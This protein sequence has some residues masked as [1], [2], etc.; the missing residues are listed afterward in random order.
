MCV[1]AG[2]W[3]EPVGPSVRMVVW[4]LSVVAVLD[5]VPGLVG[6]VVGPSVRAVFWE[7][8]D[9]GVETGTVKLLRKIVGSPVN[10][11]DWEL[12]LGSVVGDPE[13]SGLIVGVGDSPGTMVWEVSG[14]P[15]VCA[16]AELLWKGEEASVRAVLG[17]LSEDSAVGVE[18]CEL[19]D[20]T[21]L[22]VESGLLGMAVECTVGVATVELIA[23]SVEAEVLWKV[24]DSVVIPMVWELSL[25]S[26]VV[27]DPGLLGKAVDISPGTVV[28]K[29]S[30]GH[31]VGTDPELL[32]VGLD[33]SPGTVV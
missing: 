18:D 20:D 21:A 1:E 8:M 23:V 27:A 26:G 22:R 10:T 9:D 2:L 24:V 19:A 4:V 13:L 30:V 33:V 7:L 31:V 6:G 25:N 5:A 15:V 14:N 16:V 12:K 29:L 32:W 3:E 11:V 28:W 17:E